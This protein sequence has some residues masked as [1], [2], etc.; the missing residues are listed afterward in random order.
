MSDKIHLT[1]LNYLP[2]IGF[3][4]YGMLTGFSN[5]L[6]RYLF[7]AGW[8]VM[9]VYQVILTAVYT[10]PKN[11]LIAIFITL[12]IPTFLLVNASVQKMSYDI[13][14]IEMAAMDMMGVILAL[15]YVFSVKMWQT[16]LKDAPVFPII[17][18]III[19]ILVGF[20]LVR[21]FLR[22]FE[23]QEYELI[24]TSV[25]IFGILKSTMFFGTRLLDLVGKRLQKDNQPVKAVS[26]DFS[27]KG[28]L[29]TL[30]IW[31]IGIP[32][33][34]YTWAAVKDYL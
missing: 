18:T 7:L 27:E 8:I 9:V 33:A 23:K 16:K 19:L 4:I 31:F 30:A 15:I 3:A 22:F 26:R 25:L 10:P 12:L 14:F 5:D 11:T 1:L 21:F 6:F 34:I 17:F 2:L 20:F 13:I 28:I 29:I 32:I 24:T